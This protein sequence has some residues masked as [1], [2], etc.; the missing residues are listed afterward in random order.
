M[1]YITPHNLLYSLLLLHTTHFILILQH[2]L[3]T[4]IIIT[5]ILQSSAPGEKGD[6]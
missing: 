3:N 1:T 2:T 6:G 5:Y 4:N